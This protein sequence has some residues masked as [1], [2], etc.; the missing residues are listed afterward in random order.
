MRRRDR[1]PQRRQRVLRRDRRRLGCAEPVR[2][3]VGGMRHRGDVLPHR[4]ELASKVLDAVPPP[5]ALGLELLG[6]RAMLAQRLGTRGQLSLQAVRQLL[7]I[8]GRQLQ[9]RQLA[10]RCALRGVGGLEQPAS[11]VDAPGLGGLSPQLGEPALR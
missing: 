9:L 3:V 6:A 5:R 10:G 2:A 8:G 1:I 11:L 7:R 4:V